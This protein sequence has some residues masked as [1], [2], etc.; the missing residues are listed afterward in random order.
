MRRWLLLMF[1]MVGCKS[2]ATTPD[3]ASFPPSPTNRAP[4][5]NWTDSAPVPDWSAG[6]ASSTTQTGDVFR[7]P[8]PKQPFAGDVAIKVPESVAPGQNIPVRIEWQSKEPATIRHAVPDS[9]QLMRSDPPARLAGRML[10]WNVPGGSGT[11]FALYQPAR[12]GRIDVSA[13][14]VDRLTASAESSASTRVGNVQLKL[15]AS[16]PRQ[17]SVG[18]SV[19]LEAEV[20]NI[21]QV[22]AMRPFICA[23]LDAG[24]EHAAGSR[25]VELPL[26][27]LA[28]GES[29][30]IILPV[31][32]RRSGSLAVA[33]SARC[34]SG[35]TIHESMHVD[36]RESKLA[37]SLDGPQQLVMNQSA[38]WTV[39]VV[40]NGDA[41][42]D[43]V[44]ARMQLPAELKLAERGKAAWTIGTLRPREEATFSIT[45]MTIAPVQR[46]SIVASVSG[47]R[48]PECRGDMQVEIVA[49]PML[50]LTL[51][52]GD[53]MVEVGRK[54]IYTIEAKNNGSMP[55]HN[56]EIAIEAA[57]SYS[58]QH[59][60]GPTIARV[61][62]QR[63]S[64]GPIAELPRN[65][66]LTFRIEVQALQP[67]DAR[68]AAEARSDSPPLA[69]RQEA[70]TR[71]VAK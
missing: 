12:V 15:R 56:I 14:I 4:D 13:S 34:E 39:K 46:T 37:I 59:A 7:I 5:P 35:A 65:Q 32:V 23:D 3:S 47:T 67:G 66:Q 17:A 27:Q 55:L 42:A 61:D 71:I 29:K 2:P 49:V 11:V 38:E 43:G 19:N 51:T 58:I 20:T 70:A 36:V 18:E 57:E 24:L 62:G 8:P 63:I 45:A 60:V 28:P 31:A 48:L 41:P 6:P 69:V 26:G 64:F 25:R 53:S 50:K 22:T 1:L 9:A 33:I 40:N 21:G 54:L 68:L 52:G 10:E 16:G 30:A 44:A